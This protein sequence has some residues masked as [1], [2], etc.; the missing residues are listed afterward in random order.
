MTVVYFD[1]LYP[2][3]TNILTLQRSS[4]RALIM[5]NN[6]NCVNIHSIVSIFHSTI[7]IIVHIA[8]K[9]VQSS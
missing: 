1:S 6:N 8:S 7:D 4:I 5:L 3:P 2:D 9:S